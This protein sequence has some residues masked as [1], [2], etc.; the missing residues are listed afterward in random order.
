MFALDLSGDISVHSRDPHLVSKL[1]KLISQ[2]ETMI[3]SAVEQVLKRTPQGKGPLVELDF[4]R[5]R[6]AIL[7]G[8]YEQ[9]NH[10]VVEKVVQIL[11]LVDSELL[12]SFNYY[13]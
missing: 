10:G 13:K 11:K 4:W 6:N 1:E 12:S 8:I 7:S 3:S 5:E 2:W 9:L